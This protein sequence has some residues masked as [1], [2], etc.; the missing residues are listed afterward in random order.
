MKFKLV[1]LGLLTTVVCFGQIQDL[2]NLAE[3]KIVKSSTLYD[4][5]ENLYGYLYIYERDAN[6]SSKT[7]EYVLLD[8]NLNKVANKTFPNKLY[9]SVSSSYYNCVLMGD[10]IILCKYYYYKTFFSGEEKA[11]LTTFQTISL[12]DNTV[13]EEYKYDNGQFT[14]FV[15][16]FDNMKKEYKSVDSKNII[17]G[18]SND[19]FMGFYIVELNKKDYLEKDLKFF[20]E[21]REQIW[22]YTYN[23]DG[24]EFAYQTFFFLTSNKNTIYLCVPKWEKDAYSSLNAKEFKI[25]A[26]D[27]PTG[28]VKYE[29]MFENSTSKFSHTLR[30]RE[31]DN[32]LIL[33]GNYSPYKTSDF[34]LDDNLGFYRIVLDEKGKVTDEKYTTWTDFSS[35]LNINKKGRVEEN[36]RLRP[37]KYFFFKDGSVSI[38][39]E[40]YKYDSFNGYS[41]LT[42]FVLV[43]MKNDFTPGSVNIIKKDMSY[44]SSDYL[45]SQRIKDDTGVVFFYS[46]AIK[47]P[48]GFEVKDVI[49]GINTIIDGKLTEEKIS[50]YSKKKYAIEPSP[51]KEGY[52]ML[53]EFN[54]KAKYNQI[55]L[56]KLNY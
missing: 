14:T 1:L 27:L 8:K 34:K 31:F 54:E 13:S 36:Y 55:R 41:K 18:F 23:P 5:N 46:D 21:K 24:N 2:A 4:S 7:M 32:K 3:G 49:L 22:S 29:Y 38:L 12:K 53:H 37:T 25:V 39:N 47:N 11:L 19:S 45:F 20:N 17:R 51:A 44:S 33:T 42:D 43:N 40:K 15:A 28:K 35:F 10:H 56:E 50:L 26:L 52:I 9:S 6:E 30:A 48:G 16:E